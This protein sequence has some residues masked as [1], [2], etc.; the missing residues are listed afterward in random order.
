MKDDGLWERLQLLRSE[1][2]GFFKQREE[3][4]DGA[5]VAL[6]ANAHMLILG[7]PG[8]AKSQLAHALCTQIEGARYFY[9]CLN[10]FITWR[11]LAC[12]QVIVHE[13][14]NGTGKSVRFIN[15]EGQLLHSHI[16]FLDEIY[17]TSAA[18]ANSL[19]TLLNERKYFINPGEVKAAPLLTAFAASNEMP[20]KDQEQF[21]AFSD[22]FLLRYEVE[23]ISISQEGDTAFIDMLEGKDPLPTTTLT[24]E[25][26]YYL[27][28][29]ADRVQ[30]DRSLLGM[31][32]AVR[33]VLKLRHNIEAS[34]RRYK[35]A[36]QAI[37]AYAFLREHVKA[38]I[39]DL[40]IL[41]HI[42]WTNRERSERETVRRVVHEVAR[43]PN[44]SRAAE[45]FLE[46]RE[47]HREAM[48]LLD[49]A[50]QLIPFDDDQRQ[51]YEQLLANAHERERRLEEIYRTVDGLIKG[52]DGS[53]N[54]TTLQTFLN[55]INVLR[56]SLV[57]RR[58]VENPF[59]EVER[60]AK[61][62]T[63]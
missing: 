43:D 60:W 8:T 59:L 37:K 33:A 19:L 48:A 14:T 46:S 36:V 3:V 54:R 13:E 22:R 27:R 44:L 62:E 45:L 25:E 39:E 26:L 2:K 41:E 16:A 20:G 58:G 32:N 38:E 30:I 40:A 47:L 11:E 4:I 56:K 7:P 12:G 63:A 61:A 34:D 49:D 31:I 51:V 23:Y 29:E 5:L 15:T 9:F 35:D 18:T 55:E 52:A 57:E 50:A 28:S 24:L 1:F 10:K 42:L 53:G 6:L 17:K 21:H